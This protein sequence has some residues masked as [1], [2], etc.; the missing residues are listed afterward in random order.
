MPYLISYSQIVR[1]LVL[2]MAK[3]PLTQKAT[4]VSGA[5]QH[6]ATK[7]ATHQ[8]SDDDMMDEKFNKYVSYLVGQAATEEERERQRERELS[9]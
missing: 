2:L 4:S 7:R 9:E 8:R 3:G 1:W 6:S 5:Q